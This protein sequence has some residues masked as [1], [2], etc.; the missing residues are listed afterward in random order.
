MVSLPGEYLCANLL[1]V[2]S[3]SARTKNPFLL[4]PLLEPF[5][6]LEGRNYQKSIVQQAPFF[7]SEIQTLN[8]LLVFCADCKTV[9]MTFF[10]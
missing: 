3:R 9:L 1:I 2:Y 6:C 10:S 7:E 4:K 5:V 8:F